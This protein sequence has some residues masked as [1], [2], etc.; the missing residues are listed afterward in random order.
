VIPEP[1]FEAVKRAAQL[2]QQHAFERGVVKVHAM[3]G[4]PEENTQRAA[5]Q[6]LQDEGALQIRVSVYT[7]IESWQELNEYVQKNGPGD[8]L[9]NWDGVKGFVD[10]SLGSATAWF[11]R[12]YEDDPENQGFPI[13]EPSKL[14]PYIRDASQA[15][16]RLAIHAIG[17]RA[18]D[19]LL[20]VFEEVGG[21]ES[22]QRRFRIEHFQHPTPG[23]IERLAKLGVIA[24]AHPYHAIDDGRWAEQKIGPERAATTYPFHSI[25][26][27]GGHLSFGSDWTVAPLDPLSGIYAAVTRQTIDGNNPE[28]W[29]PAQKISVED[30]LKAYTVNN[31]YAGF[32]DHLTGSLEVGKRADLIILDKN[33]MLVEPSALQTIKVESTVIGGQRVYGDY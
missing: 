9:L 29:Y 32:E 31:A 33:P 10:G 13:I 12:A 15:G 22:A 28:G 27:A 16:L 8:V 14:Q 4:T 25:L 19:S 3:P 7:P 24:A 30:A 20:D 17:D 18:I 21:S 5:F 26:E 11:H 6:R 1:S 2:G 23:A